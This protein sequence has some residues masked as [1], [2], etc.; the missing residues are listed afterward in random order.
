MTKQMADKAP[1]LNLAR[2]PFTPDVIKRRRMAL[3][4]LSL[5]LLL[6]ALAG[7]HMKDQATWLN[8]PLAFDR[9][10]VLLI[11]AW[12]IWAYFLYRYLLVAATPWK[13]FAEEI[14]IRAMNDHRVL[15]MSF[16]AA[17]R[18]PIP[19]KCRAETLNLLNQGYRFSIVRHGGAYH[20]VTSRLYRPAM[21]S[22]PAGSAD[23][24]LI[25]LTSA[26]AWK[27]RLVRASAMLKA[28]L[29]ENTFSDDGLPLLLVIVTPPVWLIFYW[30]IVM[31]S[32][33]G[34]F[35]G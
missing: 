28:M 34:L 8:L 30:Q 18:A 23:Y 4:S 15:A 6:F 1:L 9:P 26:E 35:S 16:S 20:F 33:R 25:P 11:A 27:Y 32:L 22:E 2:R 14:T 12:V 21:Q 7:G 31:R 5:V 3:V 24:G 10:W 17:D 13:A 19:E 29:L